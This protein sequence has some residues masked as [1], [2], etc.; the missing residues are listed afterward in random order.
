MMDHPDMP[1]PRYYVKD[2][3]TLGYIYDGTFCTF[4]ILK[5]SVLRGSPYD[6]L[7]G[8]TTTFGANLVPAT[9]EDFE[10]FGVSPKG[11]II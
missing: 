6:R 3:H 11:H 9:V 4:C 8:T 1:K 5:A 2:G 10:K 7:Q